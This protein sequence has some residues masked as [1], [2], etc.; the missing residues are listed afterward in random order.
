[1]QN[2]EILINLICRVYNEGTAFAWELPEQAGKKSITVTDE[3]FLLRFPGDYS[4]WSAPRAQA[5]YSRV[6]LSKIAAGSERPLL[7]EYDSTLSIA[8]AEAKLVDF[9]RMKF[10]PDSSGGVSI[11]SRLDGEVT[12]VLPFQSPWR[13]IMIGRNPGDLLEKNY[14]LL[15]LIDPSEIEDV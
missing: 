12:R 13:V 14:L 10:D 8:L 5:M 7:I 11:R 1:M 4:S 2:E 3:K 9:A 15:N 6:P